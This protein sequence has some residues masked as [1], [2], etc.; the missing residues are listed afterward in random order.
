M[1]EVD[2]ATN[3]IMKE[4]DIEANI[5]I[6][7]IEHALHRVLAEDVISSDNIPPFDASIMDGYAVRAEDGDGPRR[8]RTAI[9]AGDTVIILFNCAKNLIC[10]SAEY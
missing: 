2:E 6:I 9:G 4:S 3:I 10:F 7:D 8:V 1:V 5:E